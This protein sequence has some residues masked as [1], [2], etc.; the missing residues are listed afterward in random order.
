[1][2]SQNLSRQLRGLVVDDNI[3]NRKIHERMLNGLGVEC[4][5]VANGKEAVDVHCYGQSFDLI[6]MD[7]DMPIMNGIQTMMGELTTAKGDVEPPASASYAATKELRSMGI[8]SMIV[9]GNGKG[10]RGK[11]RAPTTLTDPGW[12]VLGAASEKRRRF[13]SCFLS[14]PSKPPTC[15]SY[16]KFCPSVLVKVRRKSLPFPSKLRRCGRSRLK[17]CLIVERLEEVNRPPQLRSSELQPHLFRCEVNC[18]VW[19][20]RDTFF[21]VPIFHHRGELVRNPLGE[22]QYANGLVERFEEMDIDHLNFG[23]MVKLFEWLGY[24]KYM[25]VFWEDKNAPKFEIGLNRLRG[26]VDI[27]ELIDYLRMNRVSEFHL[28]W[29]HVIEEPIFADDADGVN[30]GNHGGDVQGGF[31]AARLNDVN[32][33]GLNAGNDVGD[34]FAGMGGIGEANLGGHN[35]VGNAAP[36]ILDETSSSSNDGYE[37]ADDEAYKPPPDWKDDTGS[38]SDNEALKKRKVA[39]SGKGVSPRKIIHQRKTKKVANK[40]KKKELGQHGNGKKMQCGIRRSNVG[41]N[42][43]NGAGPSNVGGSSRPNAHPSSYSE[44]GEEGGPIDGE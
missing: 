40:G 2:T 25:R 3:L 19:Q 44:L 14:L 34:G 24:K 33:G 5:V 27:R 11:K 10:G 36:I 38:D 20:M 37:S 9:A 8:S 43:Q 30:D 41:P 31:D 39:D 35:G 13:S 7:K 1:M 28:Y 16:Y 42:V 21:V 18:M 6:L 4:M 23:D 12:P 17:V 22:L 15:L 32:Q 29:D 26:D